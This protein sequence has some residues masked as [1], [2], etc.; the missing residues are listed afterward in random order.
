MP[1][2]PDLDEIDV[3]VMNDPMAKRELI[4]AN[5]LGKTIL[6]DEETGDLMEFLRDLTDMSRLGLLVEAPR[7]V[8]SG[9]PVED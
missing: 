5:E 8:P 9:L 4:E 7:N 6:S 2:R 3:V 1:S